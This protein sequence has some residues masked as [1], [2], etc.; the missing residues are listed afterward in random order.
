MDGDF[1]VT[2]NDIRKTG[3]CV[4]G[5]RRW[6][7]ATGI[8]FKELLKSGVPASRLMATGDGLAQTVIAKI[9]ARA[10]G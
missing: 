4:A 7:T 8:D 3:H 6:C 5:L 10:D 2:V 1:I 9:R